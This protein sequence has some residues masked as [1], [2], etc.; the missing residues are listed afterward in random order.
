MVAVYI[1]TLGDG[2]TLEIGSLFLNMGEL[3]RWV[4]GI[5]IHFSEL[6]LNYI[7]ILQSE[8]FPRTFL[9]YFCL[10]CTAAVVIQQDPGEM[11]FE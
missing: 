9:D 10:I 3:W 7:L 11:F 2:G 6:E 5:Q 1:N 8:S 4:G